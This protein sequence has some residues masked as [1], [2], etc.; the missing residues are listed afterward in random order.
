M[1]EVQ[2]IDSNA[3]GLRYAEETS[4]G[5]L[6]TSPLPVWKGLEPNSYDNFGGELTTVARN[7][8]ND[9]RQR[10]KGVVTDL[11]ASGGFEMDLTQENLQDLLQGFFFASLR[12]KDELAVATTDAG[13]DE[14]DVASGGDAYVAGDLVAAKG[15]DDA[16]N[17]GLHLVTGTP[18]ATTVP[19]TTALVTASG[20][21]GTISRVGFQ[22]ASGDV[23]IDA[24]GDLPKLVS[25]VKDLTELGLI[26]G[27]WVYI[28]GD[29]TAHKFATAANNGFARVRSVTAN[30]ITFD[31][32]Q[33]TMVT[34]A[35]TTSPAQT[36]RI[37]FGRVLKNE[38]G[39]SIIRRSYNL[40]RTLGVP[41][42]AQPSQV[43]SEY[44]TG[45]IPNEFTLNVP[46]AD[47]ATCSLSFVAQDHELRS[48]ATGVK[49][50]TRPSITEADAFN[51]SSDVKRIKLARVLPDDAAPSPLFAFVTELSISVN[52]NL[53]PN[54]AVGVLGS[55]E[56]TAG[57]FEVSASMTAYFSN[58]AAVQAVRDNADVT[59]DAH[60]VKANAGVSIDLPLVTLGEGRAEVE[61]D[62]PITLPFSADAA[63]GAKIDSDL[64][65]TLLMVFWDYLPDAAEA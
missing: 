19:V 18:T 41:D 39:T 27:E 36:V 65:H 8:I 5:V 45:A 47:K 10:K 40:E 30:E 22:F 31:K 63:T 9:S 57:T 11:D 14:F 15:F 28:G 21:S 34:E 17:N 29:A 61:Q 7:P 59:L 35:G 48:G 60:F 62:E 37:F 51:T 33:S 56:V 1:A 24:S 16:T 38:L 49:A 55:F 52:N 54:K 50:G 44:L 32:T 53:S 2:K 20:Q 64:D 4:I 42:T 26:P 3:T 25:T 58:V 13:T 23:D 43:Q 12:K 46:V 6:P